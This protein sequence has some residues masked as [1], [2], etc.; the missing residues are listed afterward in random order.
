MARGEQLQERDF[1]LR[2]LGDRDRL[3]SEWLSYAESDLKQ[4]PPACEAL[5]DLVDDDPFLAFSVILE[6]V[7]RARTESTFGFVAAGPLED[8]IK[9]HGTEV[10]DQIE[11][12]AACD[13][14][15]RTALGRVHLARNDLDTATLERYVGLGVLCIR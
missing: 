8:L 12:Q 5:D 1:N 3:V 7:H 4:F 9:F 13:E 15:L 10:I 6:L 14:K 11:E 2:D